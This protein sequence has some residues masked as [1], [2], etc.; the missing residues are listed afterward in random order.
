MVFTGALVSAAAVAWLPVLFLA[1]GSLRAVVVPE[2]PPRLSLASYADV[3]RDPLT[4]RFVVNSAALGLAVLGVNLLLARAVGSFRGRRIGLAGWT[5]AVP[6]LAIG[7]GALAFPTVL[8]MGADALGASGYATALTRPL[9]DALRSLADAFDLDRT[10]GVLL[11]LGV[12]TA[13]LPVLALSAVERRTRLRLPLIDAA[14]TLGARPV[15]ARRVAS[16]RWPLPSA[17]AVLTVVLASTSL[18]P[19][20][21]LAPTSETRPVGPAVLSLADQP[22]DGLARASALATGAVALNLAALGFAARDREGLL[23]DWLG[24]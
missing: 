21:V 16:G 5:A 17:A 19:A 22:G 18:T 14:L 13:H 3:A 24:G 6:P 2:A 7:V 10:P 1:Y 9:A 8:A 12:A 20:L 11:V 4:R 15:Q 23:R